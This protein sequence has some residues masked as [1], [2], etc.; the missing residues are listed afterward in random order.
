MYILYIP[1]VSKLR[2]YFCSSLNKVCFGLP[3]L[4]NYPCI[5]SPPSTLIILSALYCAQPT[6]A[7]LSSLKLHTAVVGTVR[8]P[9]GSGRHGQATLYLFQK[10]QL[11]SVRRTVM[12]Y[13]T[14]GI[15]SEKCVVWRFRRCVN[16]VECT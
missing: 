12:R 9:L 1:T 6:S 13:L 7:S 4:L 15:S 5:P 8:S 11:C 2:F 10:R 3:M 16:V 14:T